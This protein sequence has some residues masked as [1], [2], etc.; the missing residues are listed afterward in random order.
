MKEV[1]TD[2]VMSQMVEALNKRGPH[3][4]LENLC[5]QYPWEAAKLIRTFANSLK[6]SQE[7]QK[8]ILVIARFE[9]EIDAVSACI[10]QTAQNKSRMRVVY[11]PPQKDSDAVGDYVLEAYGDVP[12]LRTWERIICAYSKGKVD[13]RFW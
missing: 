10:E 12:M 4:S 11:S 6:M 13:K 5:R 3:D 1:L 2:V 8:G 9:K 7:E